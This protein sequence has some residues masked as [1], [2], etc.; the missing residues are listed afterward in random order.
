MILYRFA[1]V[2]RTMISKMPVPLAYAIATIVGDMTYL[3]WPRGRR[4][5]I[6]SVASLLDCDVDDSKPRKIAR[7]CMRNFC[8]YA[9]DILKYSY[10]CPDFFIKQIKVNGLEN[11]D[12]ALKDGKG[13]IL[14]SFHLGNLDLG[15]RLL[16]HLGYPVNAVVNNLSSGQLDKFL[17]QPRLQSGLK[18]IK[19]IDTSSDLLGILRRNEALA[20]MIDCPNHGQGVS[21]KLGSHQVKFPSGAAIMALRTGARVVPCGLVRTSNSTFQGIIAKPIDY[22][23]I[24]KVAEDVKAL[25]QS[26][27]Q[28]LEEM[29]RSFIDQWYIFH[30]LIPQ[31][32]EDVDHPIASAANIR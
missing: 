25:T 5:M 4:N 19:A 13:V 10:P 17:Q 30:P 15:A 26:A 18:L 31:E 27:V 16:S 32:L 28:A 11:L 24:G 22:R 2:A 1:S 12:D 20:L 23:P 3:V 6:K 21:V 14:V 7:K 29:T 8:K 9:M